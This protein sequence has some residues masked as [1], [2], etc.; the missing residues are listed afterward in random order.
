MKAV[1]W[2]G[3]R[4]VGTANVPDPR[5]EDSGD[6]VIRVTTSG[7]CGSDLH[8]YEVLTPFMHPGDI[9]GHEPMGVVEE[10][11]SGVTSLVPGQRVVVPFQISCGHCVMCRSGLQSQC[12]STQVKE[13]GMGAALFGYSELYGSVPGG[14]AEYLR[15]PHAD[16]TAIPV[17][18]EGP[19][20]R[21]VFLS[22]V[23][24]T[25]WQAVRYADVPEGGSVAV[26]GLGPIG[27]MC[28]RV[29]GHLG[30]GQVF[31]V[32]PVSERRAR[33][34]SRGTEVF[35]S[36]EGTDDL[37]QE[38]RDRT[39]GRGPDAVIDA[40]GMEAAGHGSAKFAQRMASFLPKG[41]A[42]KMME[43][44]G[45]DRLTALHTAIDLVRRGGTISLIGVYGG[46]A[47]PMPMMTLFDKQI[48]LRMG[49]ANVRRW[50]P[51]ILPLLDDADRLGVEDFATHHLSLD[52]A[53]TAYEKFQKKQDGV[54]K[55]LFRP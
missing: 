13:Q 28:C 16:N 25:A 18:P 30:A 15:V 29:A 9:L 8:L 49:Q 22:D 36:S 34:A 2:N 31:G 23:L 41:T 20:D 27:D 39:D 33:A 38:I 3:T 5:I 44:A 53:P 40:V 32:D 52:D 7:L 48:Q 37:V 19:D 35:D 26:L 54:F 50:T 55:V 47:D 14:Q 1:V 51:E 46:M 6:A 42:A 17:P 45:V 11:G 24:A 10:V 12:E 21:Y 4:D 43:T